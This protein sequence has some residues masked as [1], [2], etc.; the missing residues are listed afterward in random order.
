MSE[1]DE[2]YKVTVDEVYYGSAKI[3]SELEINPGEY[4][5]AQIKGGL[6]IND[7]HMTGA[8]GEK[9]VVSQCT[10]DLLVV[11]DKYFEG[12]RRVARLA[13]SIGHLPGSLEEA[14]AKLT[15]DDPVAFGFMYS[16]LWRGRGEP[17]ERRKALEI[18]L[19]KRPSIFDES[20][21][22]TFQQILDHLNE[23]K[24]H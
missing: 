13:D 12:I 15:R 20:T 14:A 5:H 4:Y 7:R 24:D 2:T 21:T 18:I 11:D 23:D 6:G 22:Q 3:G 1:N 8:I 17:A 19:G 10:P 16:A 9:L